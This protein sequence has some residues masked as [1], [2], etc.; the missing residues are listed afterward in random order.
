[1]KLKHLLNEYSVGDYV[2]YTDNYNKKKTGKIEKIKG[3]NISIKV[4]NNNILT[5]VVDTVS[6]NSINKKISK[7]NIQELKSKDSVYLQSKLKVENKGSKLKLFLNES[8]YSD[9]GSNNIQSDD[10][11]QIERWVKKVGKKL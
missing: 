7:G 8:R 9:M 11:K 6:N 3:T 5:F 1:M 10:I 2:E 4:V